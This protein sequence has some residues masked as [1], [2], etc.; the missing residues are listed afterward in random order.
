MRRKILCTEKLEWKFLLRYA[1]K[2]IDRLIENVAA[3]IRATRQSLQLAGLLGLKFP[4]WRVCKK[5]QEHYS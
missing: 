1:S 3:Q 4:D 2:Q 5:G